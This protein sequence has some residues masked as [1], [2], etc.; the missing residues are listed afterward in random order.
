[1]LCEILTY[2]LRRFKVLIWEWECCHW[3]CCCL[4]TLLH[5]FSV[6]YFSLTAA[7]ASSTAP[8]ITLDPYHIFLVFSYFWKT[9]RALKAHSRVLLLTDI[10]MGLEL[11]YS[12]KK[13]QKPP[14]KIWEK[15]SCLFRADVC[16]GVTKH[17]R[18]SLPTIQPNTSRSF[19]SRLFFS[20]F[21]YWQ[22][23]TCQEI[24]GQIICHD[25][26]YLLYIMKG[27]TL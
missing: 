6:Y 3:T 24:I 10:N 7:Y 8:S 21:S 16:A 20:R 1:M 5:C 26:Y 11:T 25:I 27:K 17:Q 23:E 19:F 14:W 15:S 9:E 4:T 18:W 13:W 2:E 12:A 22:A